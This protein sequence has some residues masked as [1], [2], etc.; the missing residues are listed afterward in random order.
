MDKYFEENYEN[1]NFIKNKED[2][3]GLRNSQIGAIHAIGSFYSL[4]DKEPS[5]IAMPTGSGKTAVLMLAPYI[6][7]AK[8][9]LIVTPNSMVRSQIFNDYSNL[10]TLKEIN[11]FN[12]SVALPKVY[13]LENL[14]SEELFQ[15][16]S[17]ANVI[18]STHVCAKSLTDSSEIS[19]LFDFV[20][21]DEA[22]HVPAKT[23]KEILSNLSHCKKL[24]FTATPFRLDKKEIKG[25]LIYS[26]PLSKAYEDKIFGEVEYI[27]VNEQIGIENDILLAQKAEEVF[28]KDKSNAFEHYLMIRT[29]TKE[30]AKELEKIYLEKTKLNVTRIDS[31]MS[32]KR[33]FECLNNLRSGKLD[34]IICVDMLG[35]GFDFPNL[36]IAII[37][38]PHKSLAST[39]QFVGRFARTNA[40]NIGTA[41]FVA[42]N[43]EELVIEN[44]K[45]YHADSVWNKLIIN[46]SET[47]IQEELQI[48]EFID[49]FKPT[50]EEVSEK[51]TLSLYNIRPNAHAKV[52]KINDF[53]LDGKFP[54]ICKVNNNYFINEDNQTV[55]GVGVEEEKPKWFSTNELNNKNLTL[56]IVHFQPETKLMFIYSSNK[57]EMLYNAIADNFSSSFDKIPRF[58]MNRV[59]GQ[60]TDFEIFNSGFQSRYSETGETYRISTGSNVAN[61]ID[62]S[63]GRLYSAGHIFCTAKGQGNEITIGYSSAGK[64]WSSSYLSLFE[65]IKWCDTNGEKINNNAL[66]IK[67]NTKLDS[68]TTSEELKEIPDNIFFADFNERAYT[69]PPQVEGITENTLSLINFD[70]LFEEVRNNNIYFSLVYDNFRCRLSCNN[71]GTYEILESSFD[72]SYSNKSFSIKEYLDSYPLIFKTTDDNTIFGNEILKGR[73][74]QIAFNYDCIEDVDWDKYNTDI[75]KEFGDSKIDGKISLHDSIKKLLLD[76]PEFDYIIYDHSSGEIADFIT[77]NVKSDKILVC[78]YHVKAMKSTGYNS[79]ATELYEVCGQSVKSSMWLKDRKTLLKKIL[80]RRNAGNCVFI[81]GNLNDCKSD[82]N[83]NKWLRG[84]II[85][86]QPG[87]SKSKPFQDKVTNVISASE[88]YL[89]NVGYI[90][91]FKLWGTKL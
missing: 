70:L 89:R 35:E 63:T 33:I 25:N 31:S 53:Y 13:E 76:D 61:N 75:S 28:F 21:I 22:H 88:E 32:S 26:Y 38:S 51:I 5:I 40:K 43:N 64:I 29:S 16:I 68:L 72:I 52:F 30:H 4:H 83:S 41:K 56:Y 37:H 48:K 81:R 34:G 36:K 59:L 73:E 55:I 62:V 44:N 86:I 19:C 9:I 65:Y 85:A 67:T 10:K 3:P 2:T 77:F 45:L 54:K 12:D 71:T 57:I 69:K 14:Y 66:K 27:S 8:K 7:E 50:F 39:L 24:L 1:I 87:V 23:W 20:L 58:K 18:V 84:N 47:K 42:I 82:L 79:S 46:M 6:T 60:L 78:L 74:S 49:S 90:E 11:V 80:D 17:E 15:H 91:N